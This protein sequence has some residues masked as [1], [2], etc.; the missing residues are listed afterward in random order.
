MK[1]RQSKIRRRQGQQ[2]WLSILPA[3]LL[4]CDPV[5]CRTT[6]GMKKAAKKQK[7]TEKSL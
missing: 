5:V 3:L 4:L 6:I 2:A 7:G 1:N